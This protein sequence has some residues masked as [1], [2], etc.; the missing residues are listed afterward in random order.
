MEENMF[1]DSNVNEKVSWADITDDNFH[2][3]FRYCRIG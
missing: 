2:E 3:W 1:K